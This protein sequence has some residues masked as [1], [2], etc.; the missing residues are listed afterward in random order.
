MRT[1]LRIWVLVCLLGLKLLPAVANHLVG[2]EMTYKYLDSNGPVSTPFRY[3]ITTRIYYNTATSP[4]GNPTL[5]INVRTLEAGQAVLVRTVI[6][7][8]SYAEITPIRLPSCAPTNAPGVTLAVYQTTVSLPGVPLG[9]L[10]EFSLGNRNAGITNL[11]DPLNERMGLS[12]EMAPPMLPNSSPAFSSDALV[13][14]CRADTGLVLNN[15][16]D[17]DGDRLSYSFGTPYSQGGTSVS[18][19]PGYNPTQPFGNRGYA[20]ID[21][22]SGLAK[23]WSAELGTFLLAIDVREY[24]MVN[25]REILLGR[26]R[27][28]IQIVVRECADNNLAPV[29]APATLARREV[30]AAEGQTATF[31][32]T[33]TDPEARRLTMEVTSVLLDGPGPIQATVNG[34]PGSPIGPL[35]G[36]RVRGQ[37]SVTGTFQITP[38]CGMARP[39]PYDIIVTVADSACE[40]KMVVGVFRL[41]IVR[42]ASGLRIRGD[43]VL[44]VG[45]AV[46]YTANGPTFG[47]Y[48]WTVRGGQVQGDATGRS[49]QVLWPPAAGKGSV[50]VRGVLEASCLTDTVAHPVEVQAEPAISGPAAYCLA[51]NTGL[52][53]SVAGPA[54]AYQWSISGGSITS[55]QG[56]NSVQVDITKGLTATL[57]VARA[58]SPTCRTTLSIGPD[59]RCLA[60]YNVITPNGDGQ[61]DVFQIDN[62]ARHP[63]T[64]LTIFNR[65]GR[66]VYQT[67]DY[68]NAY[69]GDGSSSGV[70]YYLCQLQDGTSYKGWFE[71][72]R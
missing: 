36:V 66:R 44:C 47:A 13:V 64:K 20:A 58:A 51:A 52:S 1:A 3:E 11:R 65:W 7:R 39:A 56:T 42:P 23:Y 8:N 34:R 22:R 38:S 59:D 31:E 70:Y 33:A 60:F 21:A 4:T 57:Q 41:R 35:M 25:G 55:G 32:L 49:V 10:A 62:L 72:I 18:Y 46:T 30:L 16:Y 43:S 6:Q 63:N 71:I 68:Q 69:S 14:I 26:L 2:G 5:T 37:G 50:A 67:E 61:N 40:S 9:Y 27:R 28:D 54:G 17:A 53:Y 12:V 45:T 24:R 15:A 29:F 48:S 19:A